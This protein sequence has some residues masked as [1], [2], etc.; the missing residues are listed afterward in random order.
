MTFLVSGKVNICGN[1]F[2][3]GYE[4]TR[5]FC[6]DLKPNKLFMKKFLAILLAVCLFG[7]ASF[8]QSDEI[9]PAAIGVSLS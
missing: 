4:H 8:G 3:S 9:R 2:I 7:S 5:Y 1:R 6:P